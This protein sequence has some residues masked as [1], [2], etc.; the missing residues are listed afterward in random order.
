[1]DVLHN[2]PVNGFFILPVD[3]CSLDQF[4]LDAF[5]GVGLVIG[6]LEDVNGGLKILR[7]SSKYQVNCECV[8]H[9]GCFF[10]IQLESAIMSLIVLKVVQTPSLRGRSGLGVLSKCE[11][12]NKLPLPSVS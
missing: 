12:G 4:R 10:G 8:N 2:K 3:S 5:N 11:C 9:Y 7:Y 6:V 1:M